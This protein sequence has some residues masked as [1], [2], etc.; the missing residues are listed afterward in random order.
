MTD[1]IGPAHVADTLEMHISTVWKALES[2]EL[3]GHQRKRRG[4]WQIHPDAVDAWIRGLDGVAACGCQRLRR[5][6]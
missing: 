6:A 1:W 5:V 3:H 2:G 4:R